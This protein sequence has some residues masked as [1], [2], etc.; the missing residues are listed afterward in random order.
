MYADKN[1]VFN[2]NNYIDVSNGKIQ[3]DHGGTGAEE[4]PGIRCYLFEIPLNK[5]KDSNSLYLLCSADGTGSDTWKNDCVYFEISYATAKS[6]L[7]SPEF[8]WKYKDPLS[9]KDTYN[10][11]IT[12]S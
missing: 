2:R 12:V 3:F 4:K 8:I 10:K 1:G 5:I 6:D 9:E 7:D 11:V